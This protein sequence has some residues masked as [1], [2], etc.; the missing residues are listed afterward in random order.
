MK[1]WEHGIHIYIKLGWLNDEIIF[2]LFKY[3]TFFCMKINLIAL[4]GNYN[5]YKD[6]EKRI[7]HY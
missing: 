2:R 6:R 3:K 4:D 1:S 5:V 7:A